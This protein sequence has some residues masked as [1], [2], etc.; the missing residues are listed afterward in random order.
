MKNRQ[1]MFI[2]QWTKKN[3]P[4]AWTIAIGT[5]QDR[6]THLKNIPMGGRMGIFPS[7]WGFTVIIP[8]RWAISHRDVGFM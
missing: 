1:F 7:G 2:L 3:I 8:K 4:M 6:A 5:G